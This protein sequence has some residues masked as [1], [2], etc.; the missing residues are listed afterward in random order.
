MNLFYKWMNERG[1]SVQH[2]A[3]KSNIHYKKVSK[4][5]LSEDDSKIQLS[6]FIKLKIAFGGDIN[7]FKIFPNTVI[8]TDDLLNLISENKK[9]IDSLNYNFK[10]LF[11]QN[12]ALDKKVKSLEKII[13]NNNHQSMA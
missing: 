5:R 7:I 10:L 4:V 1:Y 12:R 8:L 2:V 6:F 13:A 9:E 3:D 11:D